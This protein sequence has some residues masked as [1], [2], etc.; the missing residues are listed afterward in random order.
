[1]GTVATVGSAV[2]LHKAVNR[3]LGGLAG[4]G[5]LPPAFRLGARG[6]VRLIVPAVAAL[7]A[8]AVVA[9]G[10]RIYALWLGLAS[11]L[12]ITGALT[13]TSIG[14]VFWFL[15][16]GEGETGVGGWEARVVAG[17]LST[18]V[19]GFVFVFL[20]ELGLLLELL[21]LLELGFSEQTA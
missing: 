15:R 20:L 10:D 12:G 13:L 17:A 5:V 14:A 19:T 3:Q 6:P 21:L 7:G 18:V 1:M 2:V 4:D 8:V 11:G 9:T 16:T